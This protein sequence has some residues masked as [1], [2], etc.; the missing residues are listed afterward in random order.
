M[1]KIT[2]TERVNMPVYFECFPYNFFVEARNPH[3][4]KVNNR[5]KKRG[6]KPKGKR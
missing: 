3:P 1:Q 4:E 2:V 5:G 6:K